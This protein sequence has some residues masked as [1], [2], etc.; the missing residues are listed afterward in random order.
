MNPTK[1]IFVVVIYNCPVGKSKTINSLARSYKSFLLKSK[2][3]LR[4]KIDLVIYDNSK[5]KSSYLKFNYLFNLHYFHD[6]KNSGLAKAYNLA[7]NQ[8]IKNKSKWLI[9]FDQDSTLPSNYFAELFKEI[10]EAQNLCV[11]LVPKVFSNKNL[12]SPC[13]V[14]FGGIL[15]P[16]EKSYYGLNNRELFAIGSGTV[17]SVVY[18]KKIN[19]FNEA[20]WMDSLDRWLFDSINKNKCSVW[21]SDI[22]INH[23]LSVTNYDKYISTDR[24][25]NIMKYESL[26]I[27]NY[28]SNLEVCIYKI[29]LIKRFF[30]L[31]FAF[32]NKKFAYM[33]FFHLIGK[34]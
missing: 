18:L 10:D 25:R 19:G 4:E 6:P 1:I 3:N 11:A 9:L 33:T 17:I 26:F 32:K 31:F 5:K 2:E 13:R 16:L 21:V 29:R 27:K 28:R 7:F 12:I 23:Q 30:F 20:F 22:N 8:G 34:N 14:F 15:R 24:Y